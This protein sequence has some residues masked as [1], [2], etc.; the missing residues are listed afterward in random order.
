MCRHSTRRGKRARLDAH[1]S[2]GFSLTRHV[3]GLCGLGLALML[4]A[5]AGSADREHRSPFYAPHLVQYA[6]RDGAFP[7]I[8]R[9]N[10]TPLPKAAADAAI[11]ALLELPAWS[12]RARFVPLTDPRGLYFVVVFDPARRAAS[13]SA[14]C[15]DAATVP[16]ATV[17]GETAVL[18]V[19]CQANEALSAA[20]AVGP[21]ARDL[22][23]PALRALL[24]R[25]T[26]RVFA[27]TI[28]AREGSVF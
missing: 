9:G 21:A 4:G 3:H 26:S 19:F 16:L 20:L 28:P 22:A 8:V 1:D 12:A 24:A 7:V 5:C 14:A 18:G 10:P 13:G 27:F 6:A 11:A 15:A 17:P 25:V 2:W 23:D